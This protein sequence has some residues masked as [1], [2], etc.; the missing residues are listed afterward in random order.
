LLKEQNV[1]A[2]AFSIG[3]SFN[4]KEDDARQ[5]VRD[6]CSKVASN[7]CIPGAF[8]VAIKTGL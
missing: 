5:L 1:N 2:L 4:G 6:A 7:H 3:L 8:V